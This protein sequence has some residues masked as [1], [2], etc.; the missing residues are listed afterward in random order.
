MIVL[1]QSKALVRVAVAGSAG[2]QF[3]GGVEDSHRLHTLVPLG[4]QRVPAGVKASFIPGDVLVRRVQGPVRGVE[5]TV[6]K[7]RLFGCLLAVVPDERDDAV[8]DALCRP[9]RQLLEKNVLALP[10]LDALNDLAQL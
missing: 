2:A 10:Y 6:G 1:G 5:G 7:E 4:A 3:P 9:A 8:G